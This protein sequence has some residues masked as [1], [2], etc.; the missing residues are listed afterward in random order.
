M[1]RIRRALLSVYHKDGLLPLA[2]TLIRHGAEILSSGGTA[3]FLQEAGIPVRS[4]ES[5]TESPQ[6]F[7]GRVKTLHPRIH[8]GILFRRDVDAEEAAKHGI[9]P[10]DLVVVN[11]YPFGSAV[12]RRA[13]EDET[14]ELIDVGGPAMVR[15]AAK[16]HRFVGVVTLPEDYVKVQAALEE[17]AGEL[18]EALCRE[19]AAR[20]FATT[21]AY[22]AAIATYL[23]G[24]AG[25]EE[26]LPARFA[27]EAP[28]RRTLRYGENPSQRGGLYGQGS[29]FPFDLEQ[30]HGKELSYNNLLD[31][32]CGRNLLSEFGDEQVAVIIKH[33]IP[34]GVALGT[35][36]ADAYLRAREC[37]ALSAFGG[38]VVLNRSIDRATAELLNETFLEVVLAPG[39]DDDAIDL[40]RTKKNRVVLKESVA[41]LRAPEHAV[42]GRFCGGG[43]LLQT[44]MPR[45]LGEGGWKTVSTRA[46]DDREHRDL[47]F[48]WRVLKHVRSNGILFAKDGATVGIGS[49][50]TSRIDSTECAIRKAERSARDL[51]GSVMVSDAFFP[52]R[53]SVDRAASVGASAVLEPGGSLRDEESIQAA[54]EHGMALVFNDARC[55]SHG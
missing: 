26:G 16:N 5:W 49:G 31:L 21:A 28:M 37:D 50:Q 24:G 8:G 15:A 35:S 43:L 4:V 53:D 33:G 2:K 17:G 42:N 44:P 30:L 47:I 12:E 32:H 25:A 45:G 13:P 51:R 34:C 48:G 20:A 55:F 6:M 54:N 9:E 38:V 22:D 19:L 1:L 23:T 41:S 36:L 14:I 3:K 11:L 46:T 10:I 40:L 52:F 27:P 39:V 7:D 18:S 29:G